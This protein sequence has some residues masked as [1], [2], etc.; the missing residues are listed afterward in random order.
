MPELPEVETWRRRLSRGGPF[1][2]PLLGLCIREVQVRLPRLVAE[3]D[4]DTFA[5]RVRG[6]C[7]RAFGRRG[8][9]LLAYLDRGVL[10]F[11]LGMSGAFAFLPSTGPL[12]RHAHGVLHLDTGLRWVFRD[13][14]TFGRV[15]WLAHPWPYLAPRLGPEPLSPDFT[16]QVWARRLQGR[17]ARLKALLLNQRVLAGVGNIYADEALHR[18]GL[19]PL[20]RPQDLTPDQVRRLWQAL[21]EVLRMGLHHRGA[22]FDGVY[23]EGQFQNHFL[24][25]GRAGEPCYTCQHPIARIRVAGRSTHF[26]PRCQPWPPGAQA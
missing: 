24:V 6:Q 2:P 18:A 17:T 19:H 10:L 11:H 26:C 21:R 16:P 14:R 1:T 4:P 3:P 8:K 13:P 20:V 9:Y 23:P 15:A 12:P 22:T 25:Y 5:R 7:I